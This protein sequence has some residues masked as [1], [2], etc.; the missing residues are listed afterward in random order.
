MYVNSDWSYSLEMAKLGFDLC[1]LNLWP[2]ILS[3][4]IDITS[5]IGNEAWKFH[6]DAMMG[7]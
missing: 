1:D 3:F 5:V 4:C 7:T 6:D 2:L